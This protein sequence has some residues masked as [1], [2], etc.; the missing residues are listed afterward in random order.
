MKVLGGEPI[1]H[2]RT[3][4]TVDGDFYHILK[5]ACDYSLDLGITV[6]K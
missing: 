4:L 6:T 1:E 3:D 5:L 2:T